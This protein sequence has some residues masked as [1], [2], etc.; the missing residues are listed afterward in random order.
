MH[1]TMHAATV[2][3]ART[4]PPPVETG[5]F[6]ALLVG[7]SPRLRVHAL[8]LT[9]SRPEA[10]DLVQDAVALA[11]RSSDRFEPGTNFAAWSHSIVRDP[12]ISLARQRRHAVASGGA[13]P[14]RPSRPARGLVAPHRAS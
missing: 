1:Q 10:D 4:A 8:S 7:A 6:R 14:R 9:R 2:R 12:F 11:L 13:P 3:D 5:E